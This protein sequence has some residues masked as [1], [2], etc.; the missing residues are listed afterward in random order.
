MSILSNIS[1]DA[2]M[3]VPKS[4]NDDKDVLKAFLSEGTEFKGLLT[5]TGT[6][7]IDGKFE[8]EII[9]KDILVIGETAQ[10][11][12]EVTVGQILV[13]GKLIGNINSTQKIEISTRGQVI[14]NIRTPALL[15]EE[16]AILEGQC[17]MVRREAEKPQFE[18]AASPS[19]EIAPPREIRVVSPVATE[20]GIKK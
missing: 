14:G 1:K 10:V 18:L 11:K 7:R 8:G 6:V 15:M 19:K 9:T 13:K 20:A 2:A 3:R 17:E 12:A 4:N 16:G 5:F